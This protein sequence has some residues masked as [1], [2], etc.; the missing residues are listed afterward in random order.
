MQITVNDT[1]IEVDEP[2]TIAGL[3]NHLGQSS[4]GLAIAVNQAIQPRTHWNCRWLQHGDNI[5]LF[6]AVAG[7]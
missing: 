1:S 5:L 6:Q 4:T 2:L 3:L 7:G